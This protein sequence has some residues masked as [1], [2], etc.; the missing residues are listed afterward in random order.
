LVQSVLA[1]CLVQDNRVKY[2][3][4]AFLDFVN[5]PLEEVLSW[6]RKDYLQYIHP[7]DRISV[8]EQGRKKQVGEKEGVI[9][10]YSLRMITPSGEIRWVEVYSKTIVYKGEPANFITFIDITD[11]KRMEEVFRENEERFRILSEQSLM[12]ICLI[13]DE[14]IKY[15]N[16]VFSK[17]V[18][19]SLEE[20][21]SWTKD[22]YLQLV[23]PEDQS[24]FREQGQKIKN[25]EIKGVSPHQSFRLMSKSGKKKWIDV[26]T[27]KL[28]HM[29]S[30]ADFITLIDITERKQIEKTLQESEKQ[31]RY[32]LENIRDIIFTLS[33]DGTISS[34][35]PEFEK[36]TGYPCAEWIGKSFVEIIHPDDIHITTMGFKA[37]LRGETPPP[38]EARVMS[39]FGEI[40]ICETK[41]TPQIKDGKI[42][43]YLGI[44][45]DI[46]ERKKA[47]EELIRTKK[48]LEYLLKSCPAVIY[49]CTPDG[50]FETTFMSENIERILGHHAD[51]FVNKPEFWEWNIHPEDRE[52]VITRFGEIT[53]QGYYSEEYRFK[54]KDGSYRWM[55]EEAN[56]IHDDNGN[57]L[58]I[59]GF[60]TDITE[61]KK[62][63]EKLRT[64]EE[65]HRTLFE[66]MPIGLYRSTPDNK[67][68]AANPKFIKQVGLSSFEELCK[69]SPDGLAAKRN[70]PRDRFLKEIDEK[71]EV[72][73]FESQLLGLNG[74]FTYVRE[75]ARA[76]KDPDGSIIYY[77]GSVEDI[78]DRI[79][80]EKAVRESE[81]KFR[82]IFENAPIG[83]ALTDLDFRFTKVNKAI[84]EMIGYSEQE[85]T[86]KS[87]HDIT[88][89]EDRKNDIKFAEKLIKYKKSIHQ[90]R[91]RYLKKDEE[92]FWARTTLSHLH[93]EKGEPINYLAMIE[94]ITPRIQLEEGWK[95]Q[96]LKYDVTD[97][98]IYLVTENI[99]VLSQTVFKD[100]IEVGY[101]GYI[102]SRTLE[103]DYHIPTKENFIFHHLSEIMDNVTLFKMI[104]ETPNKSVILID[105]IEYL[106]TNRGF[107]KTM[108]LVY[109]LAETAYLKNSIV[110]ISVDKFTLTELQ[111][112]NLEK[113]TKGIELR[114][115]AT[116]SEENLDVMRLI[117]QQKNLGMKPSYS[118]V[119]NELKISRP[120]A[121]KRIKR[122][123]AKGYLVEH[124]RGNSKELDLTEKGKLLFLR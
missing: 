42:I 110:I 94:D 41:A 19:F 64:S 36:I 73:G 96:L 45:R 86:Q 92:F 34:V 2:V 118:D 82:S 76:I 21:L 8:L 16:Q 114:S 5:F 18:E 38:Y 32:I 71:G 40:V 62:V 101:R 106:F 10:H 43:G 13:Q 51:N 30:P 95:Q 98:N 4:Q 78:T 58:E 108:Q 54:H 87:L 81:E 83:M 61:R 55:L 35:S 15:A 84:N 74:T 39:K 12:G 90:A 99:P 88:H 6:T 57:P 67:F 69:I 97:G 68:L 59:V 104:E 11:R 9:P 100:L 111:I 102:I 24:F 117:Y 14:K 72:K 122:L 116:L 60:W 103:R 17:I 112:H 85:L 33:L 124:K 66:N 119:G 20:I 47:E 23:H 105:R 25:G 53:K 89:P 79:L 109:K 93:N 50:H 75:N 121:R 3:N 70:Y 120:T 65:Q 52:H 56:L 107:E 27:K 115:L 63:E 113:E 28:M 37:T 49:S 46:T 29:G 80:A 91:K 7:D 31:H 44:C 22:D 26:Y 1:I 77:E 48:R 123:V